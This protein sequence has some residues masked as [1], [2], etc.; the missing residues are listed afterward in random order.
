MIPE[1]FE[2]AHD[3][4]G[5]IIVAGCLASLWSSKYSLCPCLERRQVRRARRYPTGVGPMTAA[6]DGD[7]GLVCSSAVMSSSK[8]AYGTVV[9]TSVPFRLPGS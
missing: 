1:P 6:E 4:A 9:S 3:M 5:L 2:E 8:L 7:P